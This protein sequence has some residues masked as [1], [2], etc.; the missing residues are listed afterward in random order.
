MHHDESSKLIGPDH[1]QQLLG[2]IPPFPLDEYTFV[3]LL[4]ASEKAI[5]VELNLTTKQWLQTVTVLRM[6]P[7]LFA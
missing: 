2:S 1:V 3:G 5:R 6:D 4:D 7:T